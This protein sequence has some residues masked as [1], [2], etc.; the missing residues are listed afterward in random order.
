MRPESSATR[1]PQ[2]VPS[3]SSFPCPLALG[4][5]EI[6]IGR[7]RERRDRSLGNDPAVLRNT[8]AISIMARLMAD[9]ECERMLLV[10][11]RGDAAG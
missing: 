6:E 4:Y 8:Q 7:N 9:V 1:I 10:P 2:S 5:C 11:A 3:P